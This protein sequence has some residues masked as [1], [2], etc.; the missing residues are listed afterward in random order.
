MAV[1]TPSLGGGGGGQPPDDG[2]VGGS[3]SSFVMM[4]M[5][6]MMTVAYSLSSEWREAKASGWIHSMI[7]QL[8]SL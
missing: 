8:R 5:L 2:K 4:L 6:M 3:E 7:F 1:Y